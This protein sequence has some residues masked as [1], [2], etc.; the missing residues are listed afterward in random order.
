VS[1]P[2][3]TVIIPTVAGREEYFDR[4]WRAYTDLAAGQYELDL[5]IE[6]DHSTCGLAW[7]AG[8]ERMSTY[9]QYVHFT[10][11]DIVPRPG[12]VV[13]AAE[14]AGRGFIPAPQVYGPDGTPQSHP[15]V[16]Q[17]GTD[18]AEV[19][20]TALP[21][22]SRG[23]L[24]KIVPLLCTHYYSDDWFSYRARRAGWS[25]VLRTGYA[26]THYY[27]QHLRGAGMTEDQRM[28]YDQGLYE[29]A[30]K[31]A[32]SGEW[33]APWPSVNIARPLL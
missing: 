22:V 16:G 28:R 15:Q 2:V 1:L 10:C 31:M 8:T 33:N 11:D 18:W 5:V 19:Y 9:S 32:E 23:Q 12:W 6:R 20:M 30:K 3:I 26:F 13:P 29:Q 14:A 21:F 4:C 25:T 17:V 27:A 7:Q 24:E